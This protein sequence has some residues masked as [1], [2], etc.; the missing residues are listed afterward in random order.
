MIVEKFRSQDLY[1]KYSILLIILFSIITLTLTSIY[2]VSG[3]AC[4]HSSVAKFIGEERKIPLDENLGRDEPFWAPPLFHLISGSAY[5]ALN[6]TAAMKF[7]SPIFAI[8]TLI[9]TFFLA[10]RLFNTKIAFYTLIFLASIPLFIDYSVFSYVESVL[11]FFIVLSVYLAVKNRVILASI[12]AGLGILT[13]Y[14]ALFIIPLLIYIIY[15]N[16]PKKRIRVKNISIIILVPLIIASP[17]LMRNWIILGNPIWPFLNFIFNGLQTSSYS[18]LHL[19]RLVHINMIIFTYLG[20][21]GIPNGNPENLFFFNIPFINVLITIWLIG[22]LILILP[23]IFSKKI[24]NKNLLTIWITFYL[25]LLLVYIANVGFG[26]TRIILPAIPAI[27]MVWAHGFSKLLAKHK[28]L[29]SIL[30]I[31]I[32]IGFVAAE[33]AKISL[34]ANE[35][36]VYKEDFEWVTQNTDKNELIMAKG[37][38]LS[39]NLERQNIYPTEENIEK[40]DYIWVNQNF[41]LDPRSILNQELLKSVEDS[42]EIIYKNTETGTTIYKVS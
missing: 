33:F 35:W 11:L 8:L 20:L 15:K 24:K 3:D 39:Y 25:I 4:W 38:C 2:H 16:S 28:K 19:E 34:S 9:F 12:A 42:S 31:L 10:K 6:N 32:I 40:A 18:A 29:I 41:R 17:W 27:A 30:F 36:A 37:Q 21:F 22:T 23:L 13:K 5:S 1:T 7:I 14:N 26:V